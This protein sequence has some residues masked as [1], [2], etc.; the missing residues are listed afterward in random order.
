MSSEHAAKLAATIEV[1]TGAV[2]FLIA[3]RVSAQP[4]AIR[5]DLLHILQRALSKPHAPEALA[6]RVAPMR[7]D[8]ALWM[9]IV[10]AGMMDEVRRQIGRPIKGMTTIAPGYT[11]PKPASEVTEGP[12]REHA[13]DAIAHF[14]LGRAVA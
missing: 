1:L 2:G 6:G 13:R 8:L 10:A 4:E 5:G 14:E 12:S 3:E 7:G 9:P 11:G